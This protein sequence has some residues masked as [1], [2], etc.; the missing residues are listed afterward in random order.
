MFLFFHFRKS[1]IIF[2]KSLEVATMC[3]IKAT[4]LLGLAF[5]LLMINTLYLIFLY[6]LYKGI[7]FLTMPDV[8]YVFVQ[9]MFS[10]RVT[11]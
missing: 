7:H 9:S 6:K 2:T 10:P 5:I 11:P 3:Y 8:I 1:R 4:P